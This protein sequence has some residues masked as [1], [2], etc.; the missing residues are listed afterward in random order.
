MALDIV[1]VNEHVLGEF[2]V[3]EVFLITFVKWCWEN[4]LIINRKGTLMRVN[5]V[6]VAEGQMVILRACT[7]DYLINTDHLV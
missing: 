1:W 5:T 6:T 2:R 7:K 3:K 4:A